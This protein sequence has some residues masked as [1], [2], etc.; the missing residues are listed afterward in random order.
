MIIITDQSLLNVK[1]AVWVGIRAKVKVR[2]SASAVRRND[3]WDVG[4]SGVGSNLYVRGPF[5]GT[6]R[7]ENVLCSHCIR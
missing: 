7:R 4:A 5:S 3:M 1:K 6:E 2:V